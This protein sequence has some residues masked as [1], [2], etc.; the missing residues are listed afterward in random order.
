MSFFIDGEVSNLENNLCHMIK[1]F[2]LKYVKYSL[3]Q[4]RSQAS[5][6]KL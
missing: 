1:I 5:R 3:D 6:E 2:S 4:V